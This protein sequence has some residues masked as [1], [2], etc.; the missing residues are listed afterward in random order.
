[1]DEAAT[2][3]FARSWYDAWNSNGLDRILGLYADDVELTS[4]RLRP[5]G[6]D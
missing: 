2:E 5:D 3:A 1:M 4:A 6:Q